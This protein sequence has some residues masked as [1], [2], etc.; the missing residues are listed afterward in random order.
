MKNQLKQHFKIASK[1]TL[2]ICDYLKI[3][4]T[5]IV[6]DNLDIRISTKNLIPT[7]GE[8]LILASDFKKIVD[9]KTIDKIVFN[10]NEKVTLFCG[11][12][13]FTFTTENLEEFLKEKEGFE[14][15]GTITFDESFRVA[16][17]FIGKNEFSPAMMG[18]FFD[19]EYIVSTDAHTLYFKK[20]NQ[21]LDIEGM[22]FPKESFFLD[23]EFSFGLK[24]NY[25]QLTNSDTKVTVRLVDAKYPNYMTVIPTDNP[26]KIL[27]SKKELDSLLN[28]ALICTNKKTKQIV[29]SEQGISSE[30]I[31]FGKEYKAYFTSR[32]V[33]SGEIITQGFNA[34]FLLKILKFVDS[35]VIIE[36]STSNRAVLINENF[37]MMPV[38]L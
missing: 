21:Q 5:E 12:S 9:K 31:D 28:D 19:K 29:L 13:E 22:I 23:G 7:I 14:N 32:K 24:E 16:Q 26:N 30:D 38:M 4:E 15:K 18:V 6:A 8:G 27:F 10:D 20:H 25:I 3:S 11:K 35:D 37:L 17:N 34:D 33:L 2:P 1:N 36:N